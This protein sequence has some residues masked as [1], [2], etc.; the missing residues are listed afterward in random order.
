MIIYFLTVFYDFLA[1]LLSNDFIFDNPFLDDL[2]FI[3]SLSLIIFIFY[4]RALDKANSLPFYIS[5]I[6]ID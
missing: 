1:L 4:K 6:L 5:E 3:F 2:N